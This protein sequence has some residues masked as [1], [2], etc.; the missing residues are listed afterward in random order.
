MQLSIR[1]GSE[2]GNGYQVPVSVLVANYLKPTASEAS[3]LSYPE[4]KTLF[5]EFGHVMQHSSYD[6]AFT[7]LSNPPR[8]F[9]E[10]MSQIFENWLEDYDIISAFARHYKTG[11]I[12]PKNLFDT[13]LKSLDTLAGIRTH[14]S[15]GLAIYDMYL[16]D[17]FEPDN[18]SFLDQIWEK[19]DQHTVMPMSYEG[20]YPQ[21]QNHF[22]FN[23][24]VY[25]YTYTWSDVY[26]KDM[27]SVFKKNGL[28]DRATGQKYRELILSNGS[29]RNMTEALKAFL[30]RPSNN[31]A[32]VKSLD[33]N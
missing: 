9:N 2:S 14:R 24:P 16:H 10:A 19:V 12:L 13:Y 5:H 29:Q 26:A 8:D 18:P 22:F 6:G 4:L 30:G 7:Y 3:L 33:L 28:K 20:F 15:L 11:E 17:K 25:L 31:K 23:I 1:S 21:A 27:F 32:F